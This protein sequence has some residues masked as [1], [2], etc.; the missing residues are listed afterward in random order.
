MKVIVT[1]VCKNCPY[2][3]SGG[4][5][6]HPARTE[7]LAGALRA[8]GHFHCHKHL[9][10]PRGQRPHCLGATIAQARDR[11]IGQALRVALRLG[12][13]DGEW[14][15]QQIDNNK[16]VV[17]DLDEFISTASET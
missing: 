6:L 14:L 15:N 8:D 7:E 4:V 1:A 5:K 13:V 12:L 10:A 11:G 2:R 9:D 3:R 17:R 16:T